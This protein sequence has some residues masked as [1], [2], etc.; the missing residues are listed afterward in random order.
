MSTIHGIYTDYDLLA[1]ELSCASLALT[2]LL[3]LMTLL[4]K[5]TRHL[6]ELSA[7]T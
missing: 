1:V 2:T 3:L 7:G 4:R 6:G 5:D